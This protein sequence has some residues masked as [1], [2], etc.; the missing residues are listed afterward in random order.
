[1]GLFGR[2]I[3]IIVIGIVL[4]AISA[5]TLGIGII[6]FIPFWLWQIWDAK[7]TA[8]KQIGTYYST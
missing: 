2:G 7:K 8:M 5:F 1:L 6:I 3:L 4:A